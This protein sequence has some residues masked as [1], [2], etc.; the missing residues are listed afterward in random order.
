VAIATAVAPH[1]Q[2]TISMTLPDQCE[3]PFL[4]ET[5]RRRRLSFFMQASQSCAVPMS[6]QSRPFPSSSVVHSGSSQ[7]LASQNWQTETILAEDSGG[8]SA[9]SQFQPGDSKAA[10]FGQIRMAATRGDG[11]V[12]LTCSCS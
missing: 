9:S 6:S 2:T 1:R 8:R 3:T 11:Y 10:R 5:I 7:R 4:P 12:Y